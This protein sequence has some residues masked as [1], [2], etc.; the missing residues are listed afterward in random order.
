MRSLMTRVW[1]DHVVRGEERWCKDDRGF[2]NQRDLPEATHPA[3][4]GDLLQTQGELRS[5]GG[6]ALNATVTL[7]Q[8]GSPAG[9][10]LPTGEG[11]VPGANLLGANAPA[12]SAGVGA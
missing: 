4:E 8:E 5:R 9:G 1:H 6:N 2:V 10:L 3:S 11:D 7:A 12:T